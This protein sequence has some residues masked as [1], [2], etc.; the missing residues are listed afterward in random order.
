[1]DPPPPREKPY[2]TLGDWDERYPRLWPVAKFARLGDPV[3][4]YNRRPPSSWG[5]VYWAAAQ[6]DEPE[7]DR[8]DDD[9]D[10]FSEN[11]FPQPARG[12]RLF[13]AAL[14]DDCRAIRVTGD[15]VEARSFGTNWEVAGR[16]PQP[17]PI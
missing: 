3:L 13:L 4:I 8:V 1:D 6:P 5:E 7:F 16:V 10:V 17:N 14:G 12:P 2:T 9:D 15:L 11:T